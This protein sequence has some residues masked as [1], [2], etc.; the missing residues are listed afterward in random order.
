MKLRL[1][2]EKVESFNTNN[3]ILFILTIQRNVYIN[4]IWHNDWEP[5]LVGEIQMMPK[6]H[7][8]LAVIHKFYNQKGKLRK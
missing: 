5:N 6:I 8:T 3:F 1:M 7:N 4:K 2:E